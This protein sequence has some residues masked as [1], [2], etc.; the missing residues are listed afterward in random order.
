MSGCLRMYQEVLSTCHRIFIQHSVYFERA[1]VLK[2]VVIIC[3]CSI[4]LV[5]LLNIYIFFFS[6]LVGQAI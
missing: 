1:K 2:G 5:I 6:R 3:I 4:Y